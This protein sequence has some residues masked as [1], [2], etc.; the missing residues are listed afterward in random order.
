M[1]SNVC[2][3]PW[4]VVLDKNAQIRTVV[5]KLSNIESRFRFF[6][7][8]LIVGDNDFIAHVRENGCS[9]KMDYSKVCACVGVVFTSGMLCKC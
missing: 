7:L 3:I 2:L 5:N 1:C 4:Q 9:Y 6:Q 8:D